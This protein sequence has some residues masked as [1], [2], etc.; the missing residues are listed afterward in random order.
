M[1]RHYADGT[2]TTEVW[3]RR[4]KSKAGKRTENGDGTRALKAT[5]KQEEATPQPSPCQREAE[6]GH[7]R[8]WKTSEAHRR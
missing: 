8:A 3:R 6:R 4:R 2:S 5:R 1:E 7:E